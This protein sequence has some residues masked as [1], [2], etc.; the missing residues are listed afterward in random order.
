MLKKILQTQMVEVLIPANSTAEQFMIP[1]QPNM[2]DTKIWWLQ[3]YYEL[4]VNLGPVS[5]K[6]VVEK[7]SFQNAFLTLQNYGGYNFLFLAP[8]STFQTLEDGV[9]G[10]TA[11]SQPDPEDP[12][13]LLYIAY[14]PTI[15]EKDFRR[16]NGQFVNWPK[17]FITIRGLTPQSYDRVFLFEVGFEDPEYI[18]VIPAKFNTRK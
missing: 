6:A 14:P 15:Q 17:C 16:F 4:M 10:Y 11:I 1:D 12:T 7:G 5:G 3:S 18:E 13:E 8:L 2:R 9:S